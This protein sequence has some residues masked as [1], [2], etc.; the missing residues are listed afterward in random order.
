MA[1]LPLLLLGKYT[2]WLRDERVL[3]A[4]LAVREL[5]KTRSGG[6]QCF[7]LAIVSFPLELPLG[8]EEG[9]LGELV[10]GGLRFLVA[11][12]SGI[13]VTRR[14][15][16]RWGLGDT[17]RVW[18]VSNRVLALR[19]KGVLLTTFSSSEESSVSAREDVCSLQS[20]F[21]GFL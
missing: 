16:P 13:G 11:G 8:E 7:F 10:L 19:V 12:F 20:A 18:P 15:R 17:S 21:S 4:G 2:S 9:G 3:L 5:R 6:E 1:F 14:E